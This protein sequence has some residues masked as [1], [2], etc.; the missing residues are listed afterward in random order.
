MKGANQK[1]DRMPRKSDDA[2]DGGGWQMGWQMGMDGQTEGRTD[3]GYVHM[4]CRPH[5]ARQSGVGA[6]GFMYLGVV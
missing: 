4:H 5:A 1:L 2:S 6:H 3:G